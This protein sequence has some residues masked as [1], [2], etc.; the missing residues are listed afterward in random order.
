MPIGNLQLRPRALV[1]EDCEVLS[2]MVFHF[3]VGDTAKYR[4]SPVLRVAFH[5]YMRLPRRFVNIVLKST[6]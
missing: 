1:Y 6:Y 5:Y 3:L 2:K 4:D